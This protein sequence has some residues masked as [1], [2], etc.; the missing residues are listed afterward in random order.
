MIIQF[1]AC[2]NRKQAFLFRV[3]IAFSGSSEGLRTPNEAPACLASREASGFV[4]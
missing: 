4:L 3:F 1:K 2:F